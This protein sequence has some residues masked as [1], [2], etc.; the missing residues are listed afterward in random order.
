MGGYHVV[1]AYRGT[2]LLWLSPDRGSEL[3]S[4]GRGPS[5]VGIGI[6]GAI[7]SVSLLRAVVGYRTPK[8]SISDQS[9]GVRPESGSRFLP[10]RSQSEFDTYTHTGTG[11]DC[12]SSRRRGT[13]DGRG[14]AMADQQQ[15]GRL[16]RLRMALRNAAVTGA[17]D[18]DTAATTTTSSGT[19]TTTAASVSSSALSTI[20][21]ACR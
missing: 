17:T 1:W 16:L 2:H 9:A 15:E 21:D 20:C 3:S 11:G 18:D 4:L 7:T 5:P 8:A 13:P 19:S 14:V 6:A 12:Q 10:R